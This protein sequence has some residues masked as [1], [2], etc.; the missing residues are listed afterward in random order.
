MRN[1]GGDDLLGIFENYTNYRQ[2]PI[3]T[4]W[5]DA[6]HLRTPP[7]GTTE[8]NVETGATNVFLA[9]LCALFGMVK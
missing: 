2:D 8:E 1:S 6:T 4:V 5:R 9:I 7:R 3:Y